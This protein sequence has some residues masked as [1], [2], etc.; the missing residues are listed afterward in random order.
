M[1][2][3]TALTIAGKQLNAVENF[4]YLGSTISND[5]SIDAE[6]T[7]SIAKA[8]VAF[9][10]LI[11]RL[12]ANRGILLDTKVATYKVAVITSL[13]YGCETWTLKARHI[14]LLE[15]FHQSSLR[16]IS[17]IRW[18]HKEA[19]YEVLSCLNICSLQ[20]MIVRSHLRWTGHVIHMEDCRV[21]KA[22][23]YGHLTTAMSRNGNHKTYLRGGQFTFTD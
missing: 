15:N 7:T 18:V 16:K 2:C 12:W 23:L 4:K 13:I 21:R 22:L 20:S 5:A 10:R 3:G 17:R 11:K 6:I 8:S 1:L 14:K 9:G 19:N